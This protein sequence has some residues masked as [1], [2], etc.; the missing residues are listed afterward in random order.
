MLSSVVLPQLPS[1]APSV[2]DWRHGCDTA[3]K[4]LV[5][6]GRAMPCFY[7][8]FE[9]ST[10]VRGKRETRQGIEADL[11]QNYNNSINLLHEVEE[12]YNNALQIGNMHA[13]DL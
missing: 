8:S 12:A 1:A 2:R 7:P 9:L 6:P 10:S 5:M 11:I 3:D 13:N 4:R